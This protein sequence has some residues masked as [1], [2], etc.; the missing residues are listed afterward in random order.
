MPI[1]VDT[2][3]YR[4]RLPHLIN[5]GK[6]YFVSFH[7]LRGLELSPAVRDIALRCCIHDHET[8]CWVDC[9]V[10]MPDHAHLLVTPFNSVALSKIMSRL[11]GAS[12]HLINRAMHRT[13]RLWQRESFDH[14][15]RSDEKLA[16]VREYICMNPVRAG[17]AMTPD[18]YPWLWRSW[19]V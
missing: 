17:L 7:A 14:I 2:Y 16:K 5:P 18:E 8:L 4:G 15:L 10:V 11:N 19:I 9:C 1:G 13:G 3:A 6:T 12:V